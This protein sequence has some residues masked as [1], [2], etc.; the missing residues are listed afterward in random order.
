MAEV[1]IEE[2]AHTAVVD[3]VAGAGVLVCP[4]ATSGD[5][6][7]RIAGIGPHGRTSFDPHEWELREII[8]RL[9]EEGWTFDDEDYD[10]FLF[11]RMTTGEIAYALLPL[12][13][14]DPRSDFDHDAWQEAAKAIL[15]RNF[16]AYELGKAY[17]GTAA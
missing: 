12:T 4:G 11:A 6:G 2:G 1:R 13:A 17:G 9:D 5:R 16:G 7:R 15:G 3:A 8:G 14:E 10:P